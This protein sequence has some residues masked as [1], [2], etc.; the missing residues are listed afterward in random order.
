[1]AQQG[2]LLRLSDAIRPLSDAAT[3][4]GEACR[5]LGEHLLVGRVCY[6]EL[7]ETSRIARVAQ[8]WTRD[9]VFSLAGNH[10][11]EDFSWAIDVLRQGAAR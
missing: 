5:L 9:G 8:D 3:L 11:M 2:F 6:A 1:M 7:D 10:R 4:E